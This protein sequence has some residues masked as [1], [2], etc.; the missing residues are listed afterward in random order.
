S[1]VIPADAEVSLD[2]YDVSG[3]KIRQLVR[4][5]HPAGEHTVNLRADDLPAGVYIYMLR[6]GAY[7]SAGKMILLK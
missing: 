2:L 7:S 4:S 3:R 5:L 1:Y 6:S